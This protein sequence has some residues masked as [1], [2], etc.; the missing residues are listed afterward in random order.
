MSKDEV[1]VYWAPAYIVGSDVDMNMLYTDPIPVIE[2][3][4][5]TKLQDVE[6][7]SSFFYCPA[8]KALF[9][10]TFCVSNV[11]ASSYTY[12]EA[13]DSLIP[14]GDSWLEAKL[15]RNSIVQGTKQVSISMNWVFFSE[16]SLE[17][18]LTPP[19]F[20]DSK[21][22]RSGSIAPGVFNIAKWFRAISIEYTLWPGRNTIDMPKDDPLFY[23]KFRT[24]KK[25]VMK[26]F[27]MSKELEKI[28]RSTMEAPRFL[29]RFR[30]IESRYAHFFKTK[31]HLL[32]LKYIKE[33]LL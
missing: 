17:M 3:L 8:F 30:P 19:Y 23:V 25:V 13:R 22:M 31:T 12:D 32:V 29:G 2:S 9:K 28:Y 15:Q 4:K 18:E 5:Q 26:R 10:N 11:L 21:S 14:N 27:T 6:R 20:S 24:D 33:N 7:G 1:I 16:E